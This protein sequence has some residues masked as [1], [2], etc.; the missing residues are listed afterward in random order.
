MMANPW[1]QNRSGSNFSYNKK[2]KQY[3]LNEQKNGDLKYG[4]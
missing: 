4:I 1:K 3:F 2:V